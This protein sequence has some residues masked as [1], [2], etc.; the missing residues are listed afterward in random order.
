MS[1]NPF[2]DEI[3]TKAKSKNALVAF[4]DAEDIRSIKT[5]RFLADEK[6]ARPVL[7]GNPG[8]FR[9]PIDG[10]IAASNCISPSLCK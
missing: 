1:K 4:P 9:S 8:N 6:I 2:I 10:M 3:R 5:S 7:V